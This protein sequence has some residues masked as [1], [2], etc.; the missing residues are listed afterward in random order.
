V[1]NIRQIDMLLLDDLFDMGGGYVLNFSNKTFS[2]FFAQELGVD[3]DELKYSQNGT[4]KANR[5]RCF[6]Q[7]APLQKVVQALQ[8]LWEYRE[9]LQWR[10]GKPESVASA[11]EDFDRLLARLQGAAKPPSSPAPANPSNPEFVTASPAAV[12]AL[13]AELRALPAMEPHPRGYAFEKFL[14]RLFDANR[15]QARD[16]FRLKGEQIDGSFQ[17]SDATYLL[18]AKWQAASCNAQDLHGF[19]GKIEQKAAWARGLFIS[20]SGFTPEG[21]AAFGRGKRVICMD[22]DDLYQLLARNLPLALVLDRKVRHA[23]ETGE[24]FARVRDL[25]RA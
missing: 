3:I 9:A 14:K 1:F 19:H 16:P 10:S 20:N 6:L 4:S 17:L 12:N 25:F 7:I 21:L 22:G 24:L 2:L 5:L 11:K 15:L 18:E 13:L 8:G 23:A